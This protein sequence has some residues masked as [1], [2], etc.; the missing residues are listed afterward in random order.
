LNAVLTANAQ[1]QQPILTQIQNNG[2]NALQETVE[3]GIT[4]LASELGGLF[5]VASSDYDPDQAEYLCQQK[6]KKKKKGK[7]FKL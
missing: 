6:M 2:W 7:G 3:S 4:G 1:E 5:D